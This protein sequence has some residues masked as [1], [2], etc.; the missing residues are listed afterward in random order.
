MK[1]LNQIITTLDFKI[2][3]KTNPLLGPIRRKMAGLK[4]KQSFTILSNNCWGGHVYRF[5]YLPYTSPTVGLYF[6]TEDY[7]KFLKNLNHY[8]SL[9]IRFITHDQSRFSKIL[10]ERNTP[11]CPIGVL[12][13]I[14]I[15]F[16]HYHS[17]EEARKKWNRRKERMNRTK[18]IVKMSEQNLCT[19]DHLKSFDLLPYETKFVFV[20]KDYGISS[21]IVCKEFEKY[22]EVTNDTDHFRR[23]VKLIKLVRQFLSATN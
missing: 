17:E 22:D 2:R 1:S 18:M 9:D 7:L 8:L 21:Q 20:H 19:H 23:H 12:D 3:E 11:P 14:E 5:F 10:K 4:D 16:L 15:I 6:F 13:D